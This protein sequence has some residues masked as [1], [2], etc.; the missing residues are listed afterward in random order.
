MGPIVNLRTVRKQARRRRAEEEAAQNRLAHG[1]S[2]AEK[3]L[4]RSQT[5][6]AR[7]SLDRHRIEREDGT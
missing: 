3:A 4:R 2:K 5:D 6:K 7:E 1:L